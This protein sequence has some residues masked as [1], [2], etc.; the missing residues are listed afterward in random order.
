[1]QSKKYVLITGATSG[2]GLQT[3]KDLISKGFLVFGTSR[4][5]QKEDAAKKILGD[6]FHFIR[7]DL[8]SRESIEAIADQAKKNLNDGGLYA[9][10]N[11][12]GTF[13]SRKALSVDGIDMPFAVNTIAPLYLSL[14]LYKNLIKAKGRIINVTSSSHYRTKI[15]W[16]DIQVA[17]HY[18]QLKADKQT[19]S[20]AVLLSRKFNEYSPSVKMYMAD[21]GLVSTEIGFKNTSALGK[22]VWSHRKSIGQTV[23]QGASTSLYLAS[24]ESLPDDFYFKYSKPVPSSKAT[25][26]PENA[27][28]IWDYFMKLYGINP[29]DFIRG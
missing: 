14:L 29:L 18:G 15:N 24:E 10:I 21:P 12:A 13:F 3:A 20:F 27:Q 16:N 4:S 9:L 7:G 11:N 28:K 1:M 19:K 23:E 8:S 25:Q 26:S 22:L 17:N 2:I 5:A 6:D